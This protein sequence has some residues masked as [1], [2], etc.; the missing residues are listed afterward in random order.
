VFEM[1]EEIPI[2]SFSIAAFICRIID[3]NA[4]YLIIKRS[5]RTLNGSWQMLSGKVEKGESGVC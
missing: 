1:R 5:G 2:K 4:Q 3:G